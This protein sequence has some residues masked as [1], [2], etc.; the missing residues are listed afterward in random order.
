MQYLVGV[1]AHARA[2][3]R[4]KNDNGEAAL[5]VHGA[6]QWHGDL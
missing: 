1:R 5:V 4:G 2:L 3:A 6:V